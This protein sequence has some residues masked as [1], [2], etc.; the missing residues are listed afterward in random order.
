M[1]T[2]LSAAGVLLPRDLVAAPSADRLLDVVYATAPVG[3]PG[4]RAVTRAEWARGLETTDSFSVAFASL[5]VA[6]CVA[7]TALSIVNTLV[8]ATFAL[9]RLLGLTRAQVLGLGATLVPAWV[10]LRARPVHLVAGRE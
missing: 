6:M 4:V 1:V 2:G 5:L 7:Y 9:L 10:T 8:T 3:H